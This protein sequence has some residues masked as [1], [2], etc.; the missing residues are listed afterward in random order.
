MEEITGY[1]QGCEKQTKHKIVAKQESIRLTGIFYDL[2]LCT[3]CGYS[4]HRLANSLSYN[5]T[6][7]TGIL[8][9]KPKSTKPDICCPK[10]N[11]EKNLQITRTRTEHIPAIFDNLYECLSCGHTWEDKLKSWKDTDIRLELPGQGK[12]KDLKNLLK[13]AKLDGFTMY[14]LRVTGV[15]SSESDVKISINFE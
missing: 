2:I 1:C 14:N 12:I 4:Y 5:A 13:N 9:L 15:K 10:C 11:E 3:V 8:N 6:G 7:D